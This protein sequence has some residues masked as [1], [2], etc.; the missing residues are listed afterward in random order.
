MAKAKDPCDVCENDA[1][2]QFVTDGGHGGTVTRCAEH[3]IPTAQVMPSW[4]FNYPKP[5]PPEK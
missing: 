1:V 3:Q 4:Q 5:A 2:Q